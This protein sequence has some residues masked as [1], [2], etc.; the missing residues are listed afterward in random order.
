MRATDLERILGGNDSA[1]LV[2]KFVIL[3]PC[4]VRYIDISM[5]WKLSRRLREGDL[6]SKAVSITLSLILGKATSVLWCLTLK[7]MIIALPYT[8]ADELN[9]TIHEKC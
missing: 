6:R 2:G 5:C 9:E 7:M 1:L 8:V 4:M 3:S